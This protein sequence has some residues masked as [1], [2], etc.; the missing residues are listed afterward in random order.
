VCP[1]SDKLDL[2]QEGHVG[3]TMVLYSYVGQMISVLRQLT[4][5]VLLFGAGA[6]AL[7]NLAGDSALTLGAGGGAVEFRILCCHDN[8][9]HNHNACR[10]PGPQFGLKTLVPKEPVPDPPPSVSLQSSMSMN[11]ES[12]VYGNGTDVGRV[13][14][15]RSKPVYLTTLRL[16]L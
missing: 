5:V 11:R 16:R 2:H 9:N 1:I 14:P 4:F 8:N 15:N 6:P 7:A 12:L 3:Y 13:F 10:L